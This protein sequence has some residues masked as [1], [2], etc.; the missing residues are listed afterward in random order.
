M[1]VSGHSLSHGQRFFFTVMP[2][3]I[4]GMMALGLYFILSDSA[5]SKATWQADISRLYYLQ[6]AQKHEPAAVWSSLS[7]SRIHALQALAY[8]PF[9]RSLWQH[10]V[11]LDDAL[12][13][14]DTISPQDKPDFPKHALSLTIARRLALH[15]TAPATN[16]TATSAIRL[17]ALDNIA[18]YR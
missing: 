13:A 3:F 7:Q 10:L 15:N 5:S 12:Y 8:Q 4:M 18:T 11:R 16:D 17:G 2:A 9:D 14:L 1:G 6:S